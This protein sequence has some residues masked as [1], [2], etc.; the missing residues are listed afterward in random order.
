MVWL[1]INLCNKHRDSNLRPYVGKSCSKNITKA[2]TETSEQ[3][4]FIGKMPASLSENDTSR[5]AFFKDFYR[6]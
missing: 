6:A 1:N 5:R 3:N 4:F 2:L